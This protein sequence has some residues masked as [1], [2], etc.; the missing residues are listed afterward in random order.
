M[1]GLGDEHGAKLRDGCVDAA[2][3]EQG[4]AEVV[5]GGDQ[6]RLEPQGR[7]IGGDCGGG[8][9]GADQS[10]AEIV[11]GGGEIGTAAQGGLCVGAGLDDPAGGE[12]NHAEIVVGCGVAGIKA[13]T[14]MAY[15]IAPPL[16][17][18]YGNDAALKAA[19]VDLVTYVPPPSETNYSGAFM[20]GSQAACK[21]ACARRVG[22]K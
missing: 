18:T 1:V 11:V 22:A 3:L 16:E 10:V 13:G 4:N 8:L 2:A 5:T 20:T 7:G 17:A 12:R 21:A 6:V 15:L 14:P 9:A 19:Q